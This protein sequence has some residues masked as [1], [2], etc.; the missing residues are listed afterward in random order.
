MIKF[1]VYAVYH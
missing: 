1:L